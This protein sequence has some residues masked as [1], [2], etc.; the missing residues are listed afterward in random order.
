MQPP[1]DGDLSPSSFS[2]TEIPVPNR[3]CSRIDSLVMKLK[4]AWISAAGLLIVA[5]GPCF[6][7]AARSE[8]SEY[9]EHVQKAQA[10]LHEKR[11]DLAIPE[12]QAAVKIEPENPETQGNLGVLLFF[13]GNPAAAIPHLRAAVQAEPSLA[14]IQGLLGIAELHTGDISDGRSDL[15]SAFPQIE[16]KQF[17]IQ[18]GLELVSSW[19][20]TGDLDQAAGILMQLEK[21]APN[22]PEVLYAVY[23]TFGDL[24]GEARLQLSVAAPDSAQTHQMLAHEDLLEGKTNAAIEQYRQAIASDPRLPDVHYELGELLNT[25]GDPAIRKEAV[26]EFHIA[27]Q[28]NPYN[29]QAL[30]SLAAIALQNGDAQEALQEYSQAIHLQPSDAAAHLGLAKAFMYLNE[31]PKALPEIEEAVRLEPTDPIAH[32]RLAL[33]YRESGRDADA[34]RQ[35]DLFLQYRQMKTKLRALYAGLLIQPKEIQP[36]DLDDK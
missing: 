8:Q 35:M 11:P 16:D 14:K 20:M 3:R 21:V 9:S 13:Q 25:A 32:Y 24:A 28:Q 15:G 10:Y 7:Q 30:C 31:K 18:A 34:K 22:D 2:G 27:L 12:L 6:A 19:T 1:W 26:T 17:K 4:P 36:D 23:R 29:E 5:A 33:L